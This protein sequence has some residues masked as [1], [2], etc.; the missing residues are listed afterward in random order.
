M[1]SDFGV[2]IPSRPTVSLVLTVNNRTP[3]VSQAVADSFRLPGNEVDEAVIV[4][5]R[6]TPEAA[7]GA[8]KAWTGSPWPV[9]FI[10]LHGESG[11]ICPANAW[12]HGYEAATSDLIYQ[13][14]SEVIQAGG[15][16]ERARAACA[17]GSTAVFGS[18]ENSEKLPLVNG[19]EPGFLAGSKMPRALGFIVC[20]PRANMKKIGGNDLAFMN[21][22]WFEDDDLFI[23]LW[24]T[25]LNFLF[26]DAIHGIH[27]NHDRQD[28]STP[29]GQ[30][31]IHA[32]SLVML[33]KHGTT[34]PWDQ[35][36]RFVQGDAIRTWWRHL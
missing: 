30:A 9:K 26:D 2:D 15:N 17:D 27:L 4:L 12:N 14:S 16:V 31:K 36:P 28:L 8:V 33:K 6:A 23:R 24:R 29:E 35:I 20:Y 11:W 32:N 18:C 25:G 21:G 22:F 19:A 5:D 1:K 3:E 10:E 13:I 7:A 34:R